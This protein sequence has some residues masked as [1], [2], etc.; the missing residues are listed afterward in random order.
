MII[1]RNIDRPR[2]DNWMQCMHWYVEFHD[3]ERDM[4]FPLGVAYVTAVPE[5]AWTEE[6]VKAGMPRAVLD[7]VLVA[8]LH[9]RKGIARRLVAACRKRWPEIYLTGAI[10]PE[11]KAL[12]GSIKT[13]KA[14]S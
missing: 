13:K 11:G 14:A 12:L 1:F 6:H 8:D 5:A 3:D 4:A 10:S 7:F 9:R 2:P